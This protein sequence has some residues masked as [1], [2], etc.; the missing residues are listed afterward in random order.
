M[1]TAQESREAFKSKKKWENMSSKVVQKFYISGI[2]R[3]LDEAIGKQIEKFSNSVSLSLNSTA[4]VYK[5]S[6]EEILQG[7]GFENVEVEEKYESHDRYVETW[8]EVKF[9]F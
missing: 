8:L 9:T 5:K 3:I 6:I 1:L 7:G 4:I 2:E